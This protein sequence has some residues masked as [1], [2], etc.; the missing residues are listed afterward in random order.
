[1]ELELTDSEMAKSGSLA[2]LSKKTITNL[3]ECVLSC[4]IFV[5]V[6]YI[7]LTFLSV[8]SVFNS[9]SLFVPIGYISLV[10]LISAPIALYGSAKQNYIALFTFFILT[11]YQLYALTLYIWFNIRSQSLLGNDT[12]KPASESSTGSSLKELPLHQVTLGAYTTAV[13]LS[14][15]MVCLKIISTTCQA[16]ATRVAPVGNN[17][18]E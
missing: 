11:S 14:L 16:E 9:D 5:A 7:I 6:I 10:V 2:C 8:I 1:M 12:N 3:L 18:S 4:T 13:M 15:V 17:P